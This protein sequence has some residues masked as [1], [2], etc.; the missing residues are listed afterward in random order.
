[1]LIRYIHNCLGVPNYLKN[2]RR[3]ALAINKRRKEVKKIEHQETQKRKTCPPGPTDQDK[4]LNEVDI[5]YLVGT[6]MEKIKSSLW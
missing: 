1:M 4:P 6:Y 5:F 3:E 2:L